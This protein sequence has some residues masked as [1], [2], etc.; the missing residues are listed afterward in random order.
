MPARLQHGVI[1]SNDVINDEGELVCYA[2]Y[3]DTEHVNV[4]EALKN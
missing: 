3:V 4:A 2:F 1:T